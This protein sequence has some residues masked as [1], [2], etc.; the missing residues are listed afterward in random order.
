M[1]LT[2]AHWVYAVF[3]VLVIIAMARRHDALIPCIAGV[4]TL[5]WIATGTPLGAIVTVFKSVVVAMRELLDIIVV[6]SLIVGLAAMLEKIGAER[7][8][9]A[10]AAKMMLPWA[11]SSSVPSPAAVVVSW[12]VMSPFWAFVPP[13]SVMT[14]TVAPPVSAAPSWATSKRWR[15]IGSATGRGRKKAR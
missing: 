4:F 15:N 10:P 5:G 2:A 6:I 7:L 12:T 3:V 1:H 13:F 11:C 9:V 8:M 14:L